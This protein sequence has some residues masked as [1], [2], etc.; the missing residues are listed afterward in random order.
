MIRLGASVCVCVLVVYG[1]SS[2]SALP[3]RT[4]DGLAQRDPSAPAWMIPKGKIFS[5]RDC[6]RGDY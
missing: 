6:S 5:G 3:N 1:A 4:E 2:I